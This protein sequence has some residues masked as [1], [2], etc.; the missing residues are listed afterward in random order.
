LRRTI[1]AACAVLALAPAAR[2]DVG[3]EDVWQLIQPHHCIMFPVFRDTPEGRANNMWLLI[4]PDGT[5]TFVRPMVLGQPAGGT[6][7][8]GLG[9]Q[10]PISNDD[11]DSPYQTPQCDAVRAPKW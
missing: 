11:I 3:A 7:Y 1:A 10:G 4:R 2:A 8:I 5:A 9:S 6:S